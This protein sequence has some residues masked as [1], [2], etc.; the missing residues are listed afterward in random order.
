VGHLADD[1]AEAAARVKREMARAQINRDQEQ[2][3]PE[4]PVALRIQ[5]WR[6]HYGS[7]GGPV[8]RQVSCCLSVTPSCVFLTLAQGA[9]GGKEPP[10]PTSASGGGTCLGNRSLSARPLLVCLAV[11]GAGGR[12]ELGIRRVGH[13]QEPDVVVFAV[14]RSAGQW[15]IHV[16]ELVAAHKRRVLQH[17][18]DIVG[19]DRRALVLVVCWEKPIQ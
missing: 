6:G 7:P 17:A 8:H 11:D 1:V 13:R 18:L 2:G 5:S 19:V 16:L 3:N 9:G 12:D 14:V 4:R 10:R 15:L